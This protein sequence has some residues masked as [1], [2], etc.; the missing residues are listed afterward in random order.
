MPVDHAMAE[1]GA[2]HRFVHD[3]LGES[4]GFSQARAIGFAANDADGMA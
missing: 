2:A 4:L 1:R 3:A